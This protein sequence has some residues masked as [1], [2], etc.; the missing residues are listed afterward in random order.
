ML[1]PKQHRLLG[2]KCNI[3]T[4]YEN[5]INADYTLTFNLL[6]FCPFLSSFQK[7]KHHHYF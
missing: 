1:N 2:F 5:I 7:K 3:F 4:I 6:L